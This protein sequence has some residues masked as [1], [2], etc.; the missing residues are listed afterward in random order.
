MSA[1]PRD[2]SLDSTL[3]L[4]ADPYRFIFIARRWGRHQSDVFETRITMT[5]GGPARP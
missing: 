3:A 5:C 4:P 1:I 2:G